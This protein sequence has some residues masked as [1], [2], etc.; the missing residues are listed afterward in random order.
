MKVLDVSDQTCVL[1]VHM[2]CALDILQYRLL[3]GPN[4]NLCA[5]L[6]EPKLDQAILISQVYPEN[7]YHDSN[8]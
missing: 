4:D 8:T 2:D 7:I 3:T 5:V 1:C 6:G